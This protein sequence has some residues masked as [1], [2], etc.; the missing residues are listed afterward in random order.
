ML[1]TNPEEYMRSIHFISPKATWCYFSF[2][3]I[4]ILYIKIRMQC[5]EAFHNLYIRIVL[6]HIFDVKF[7]KESIYKKEVIQIKV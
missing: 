4:G 1:R 2:I 6:V 3:C 7:I 5:F